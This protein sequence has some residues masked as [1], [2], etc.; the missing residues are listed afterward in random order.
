MVY[1]S[2]LIEEWMYYK[3]GILSHKPNPSWNKSSSGQFGLDHVIIIT[4]W[5]TNYWIIKNSWGKCK[6]KDIYSFLYIH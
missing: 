2:P 5:D 3:K 4:G 1:I 6:Q